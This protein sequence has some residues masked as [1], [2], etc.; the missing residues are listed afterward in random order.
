M[1]RIN[2]TYNLLEI[3][4]FVI[5]IIFGLFNV[6]FLFEFSFSIPLSLRMKIIIFVLSGIMLIITS[7]SYLI[8]RPINK[9]F[10]IVPTIIICMI[11]LYNTYLIEKIYILKITS[12]DN[13]NFL[14]ILQH[15]KY[16][17]INIVLVIFIILNFNYSVRIK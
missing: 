17:L 7:I 16:P 14:E 11:Y 3:I 10:G 2:K 8:H 12:Q 5:A 15:F 13:D 1:N 9:M 6:L 4:G